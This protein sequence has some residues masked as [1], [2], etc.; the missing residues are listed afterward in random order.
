MGAGTSVEYMLSLYQSRLKS[1]FGRLLGSR[2]DENIPNQLLSVCMTDPSQALVKGLVPFPTS[3]R[4]RHVTLTQCLFFIVLPP[5]YSCP[6]RCRSAASPEDSQ[7][8]FL[9]MDTQPRHRRLWLL[10][11]LPTCQCQYA[12]SSKH[13]HSL[14]RPSFRT[15]YSLWSRGL[16]SIVRFACL[17]G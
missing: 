9:S 4:E 7:V 2:D 16:N 12:R 1:A 10:P 11:D 15:Y 8:M 6:Q 3:S 14:S 17:P 5:T 13:L